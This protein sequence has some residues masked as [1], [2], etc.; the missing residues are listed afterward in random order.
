MVDPA[1][2][3]IESIRRSQESVWSES[4]MRE[5][6]SIACEE[7]KATVLDPMR[8]RNLFNKQ[9]RKAYYSWLK[10]R[11]RIGATWAESREGDTFQQRVYRSYEDYL[12]HQKDKV[13][14][15]DLNDYDVKFRTALRERLENMDVDWPSKNVLCLAA[16]IGTEVKAFL[17]V[18][19]FAVGLDLNPGEENKYVVFGDFHNIQFPD[20]SVDVVYTNSLDHVFE[21]GKVLGEVQRVLR[22]EGCFIVEPAWGREEGPEPQYWE[23]YS[24][25]HIDDLVS[26]IEKHSFALRQK[27]SIAVP[28]ASVQL[29]FT[30][31]AS[32]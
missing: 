15:L 7:L 16:R 22:S 19:A 9:R 8:V 21:L 31:A 4:S 30:C 5:L 11:R 10:V 18:G 6:L 23:S 13:K 17:D 29:C 14:R 26:H 2:E 12:M 27:T 32:S 24:W 1:V 25:A 3:S 20:N 28:H